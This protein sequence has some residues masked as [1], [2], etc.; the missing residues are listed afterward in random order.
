MPL[1]E[2]QPDEI[3]ATAGKPFDKLGIPTTVG[4]SIYH[5]CAGIPKS[6]TLSDMQWSVKA[7]S[8]IR[9][10]PRSA[11]EDVFT[12]ICRFRVQLLSKEAY[13]RVSWRFGPKSC[14]DDIFSLEATC[15]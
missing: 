7:L 11:S 3:F 13:I 1:A 12:H 2:R 9:T 5:S 6:L 8:V 14:F 15:L 4:S 10:A